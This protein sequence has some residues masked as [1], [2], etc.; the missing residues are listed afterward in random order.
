MLRGVSAPNSKFKVYQDP[1]FAVGGGKNELCVHKGGTFLDTGYIY[2]PY[3]PLVSSPS[4]FAFE[5]PPCPE[6]SI[7]DRIGALNDPEGPV[8]RRVAAYDD[9]ETRRE[10]AFRKFMDARANSNAP[11]FVDPS[12]F[13]LSRASRARFGKKPISVDESFFGTVSIETI[14]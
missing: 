13:T 14:K 6:P 1:T 4:G 9:W 10:E 11:P 5:N 2:A 7:I 8:A 12:D 3:I